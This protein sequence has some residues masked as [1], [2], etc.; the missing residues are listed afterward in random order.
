[1]PERIYSEGLVLPDGRKVRILAYD[2]GSVRLRLDGTPYV[3]EEAFL[4]GGRQDHA[5]IKLAPKNG[6]GVIEEDDDDPLAALRAG[7]V[8]LKNKLDAVRDDGNGDM[9]SIRKH[10]RE[11]MDQALA[12]VMWMIDE[13]AKPDDED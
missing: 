9:P 6:S 11:G 4:S 5:I 1:M 7:V 8:D 13:V 3:M 2:D 10:Q 12:L